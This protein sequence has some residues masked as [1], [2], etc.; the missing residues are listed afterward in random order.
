VNPEKKK[1]EIKAWAKKNWDN[2]RHTVTILKHLLWPHQVYWCE[3]C[4]KHVPAQRTPGEV[5]ALER[6]IRKLG[7]HITKQERKFGH[8][9]IEIKRKSA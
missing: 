9:D 5:Y 1:R 8:I 6:A 3:K 7:G 2:N 4:K